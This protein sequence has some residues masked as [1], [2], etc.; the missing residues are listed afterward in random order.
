MKAYICTGLA[1]G[2]LCLAAWL[3][4]YNT[5]VFFRPGEKDTVIFAE[6]LHG[7]TIVLEWVDGKRVTRTIDETNPMQGTD[8]R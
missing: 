2:F 8:D 3:Y 1:G 6:S 4:A 5:P 7:K